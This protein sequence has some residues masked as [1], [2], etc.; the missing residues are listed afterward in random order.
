MGGLQNLRNVSNRLVS[1]SKKKPISKILRMPK[2]PTKYVFPQMPKIS[3]A[4]FWVK[5]CPLGSLKPSTLR[6]G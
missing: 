5:D 1:L 4:L 3:G 2:K 6:C